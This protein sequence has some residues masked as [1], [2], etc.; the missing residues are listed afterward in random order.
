M[1]F[2]VYI[3]QMHDGRLYVGHSNNPPRRHIEHEQGKGCRTTGIFG[4][5]A[6]I[7]V[8]EHPDRPAAAKRE[9]QI[10]GWTPAKKLALAAGNLS[11][12]HEL[13]KRRS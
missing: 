7:Y 8:E 3:L 4:A 6:I 13:A 2:Y 12:L 1:P 9:R 11:D 10:K 5:G